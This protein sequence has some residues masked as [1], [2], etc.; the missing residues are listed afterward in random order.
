MEN[1]IQDFFLSTDVSRLAFE[2]KQLPCFGK[3]LGVTAQSHMKVREKRPFLSSYC[4]KR[5]A[6]LDIMVS[7]PH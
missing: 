6:C 5:V 3:D 2:G 7:H 4:P 1:P